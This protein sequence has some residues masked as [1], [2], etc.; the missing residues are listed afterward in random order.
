VPTKSCE[1]RKEERR[2]SRLTQW[3]L[4]SVYLPCPTSHFFFSCFLNKNKKS[5]TTTA[6]SDG[7]VSYLLVAGLH[8]RTT[9]ATTGA[10]QDAKH[11]TKTQ[12][13]TYNYN[14]NNGSATAAVVLALPRGFDR[15]FFCRARRDVLCLPN[16]HN[17]NNNNSGAFWRKRFLF[18]GLHSRTTKQQQQQQQ[19]RGLHK[20]QNN[21]QEHNNKPTTTT[22]AQCLLRIVRK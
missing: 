9:K 16:N 17:N 13:Q 20:M 3:S 8:L 15:Q 10:S 12:Q 21:L 4:P 14:H 7:S 5:T 11:L 6:L 2:G 18:S 1:E 19:Q 22:R